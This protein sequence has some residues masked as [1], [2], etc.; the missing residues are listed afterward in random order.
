MV[1]ERRTKMETIPATWAKLND[2]TWGA[3][4]QGSARRGDML[5][6]R[7]RSGETKHRVVAHV[8]YSGNGISLCKLSD[9][10]PSDTRDWRPL[11]SD[12][13]APRR[14]RRYLPGVSQGY[15]GAPSY[16]EWRAEAE[17]IANTPSY[18]EWLETG[19]TDAEHNDAE[20]QD[21]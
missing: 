14:A 10:S 13:Y 12:Q 3:K 6:I 1:P 4:V 16:R 21:A 11:P 5:V 19:R 15:A 2:G 20:M 7:N 8:L 18:D 17:A 9:G